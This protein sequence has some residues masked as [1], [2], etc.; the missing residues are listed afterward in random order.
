[1]IGRHHI[2]MLA[3]AWAASARARHHAVEK[4]LHVTITGTRPAAWDRQSSSQHVRSLLEQ[5]LLGIVGEDADAVDA[6][7]DHAV[8]NA[9]HALFVDPTVGMEG[10]GRDGQDAGERLSHGMG[11]P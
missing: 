5:E 10:C 9:A 3:P 4:W 7:V 2:I 8:D 1:M 6:L 11:A